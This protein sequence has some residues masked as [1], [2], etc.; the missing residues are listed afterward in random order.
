MKTLIILLISLI[1]VLLLSAIILTSAFFWTILL[2]SLTT[3]L[4][5]LTIIA[6]ASTAFPSHLVSRGHC[7][8]S[9]SWELYENGT[10]KIYGHGP[11]YDFT[12]YVCAPWNHLE[13][14]VKKAILSEG[15]T[16]IGKYA[17]SNPNRYNPYLKSINIPRGCMII[18]DHAFEGCS[19]LKELALPTSVILIGHQALRDCPQLK[20]YYGVTEEDL[21]KI[22]S[23]K[24]DY[25]SV[26]K[27]SYNPHRA[28]E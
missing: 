9:I 6:L 16:Q 18:G 8:N 22:F 23:D 1:L 5:L 26:K 14:K 25:E 24:T 27:I 12:Q 20:V 15:I 19:Q 3:V 21:Y 10:L 13:I 4:L 28:S 7:G 2:A 11:M 17:F